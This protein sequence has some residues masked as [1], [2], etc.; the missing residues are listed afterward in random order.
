M[1]IELN[2]TLNREL[3]MKSNLNQICAVALLSAL[4]A[5]GGSK[6]ALISQQDINNARQAG[7]LSS[8]YSKAD[9]L[10]IESSGSSKE[11]MI[12][13]QSQIAKFLVEDQKTEIDRVLAENK[14]EYDLVDRNSLRN[15]IAQVEP[16]K[17]WDFSR[18]SVVLPSLKN[19]LDKT[20]HEISDAILNSERTSKD[21]VEHMQWLKKASVLAGSGSDEKSLYEMNLTKN[22]QML[23]TQGSEAYKKRMFNISLVS[24]QKGLELDPGNIQFESMA[25]QSDAALFEQS[26]RNALENG[27]PELAYQ[28]LQDVSDKPQMIQVKKKM[29][30]SILVLANYFANNAK[31][32]YK[33]NDLL[34]AYTEFNRGREI[35]KNLSVSNRGFIQEKEYL[36]MLMNKASKFE[37]SD[38]AV[39][40]LLS[41]IK[42]FDPGYPT[43]ENQIVSK[44]QSLKN[45]ATTKLSVTEFKEV[46]SSNSV[47]ASLGRRVGSKL[48]KILFDKLGDQLQIVADLSALSQPTQYSGNYLSVEGEVLQAAIETTKN[49]GQRSQNVLIAV[50]KTET[51]EYKEW[52]ERK[53]GDA[54]TQFLEEEIKEDILIQVEHIKKLAVT[55]VAYRIIA[56]TT[57]KVLVTNN[58]VK[59]GSYSGDSVNEYQ[60]G[61]FHQKYIAADLPSDIKIMDNLATELSKA[62]GE[63][64][65]KYLENPELSYFNAYQEAV[66][67]GENLNAVELISNAIVISSES[68]ENKDIWISV[69]KQQVLAL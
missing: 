36:D 38:G 40:G 16:M 2:R 52:S 37:K 13:I 12:G 19:Q 62:V 67:R 66:K 68:N 8:L 7:K 50:K 15:L 20:N 39:F 35:Q 28:V 44:Q 59:E 21:V 22:I 69:L 4:L 26:F 54:P 24:A 27:K 46:L 23:V 51:E 1:T 29:E 64:L 32:A 33:K 61:L 11:E 34:M 6:P 60:K 49:K 41:V 58:I 45:R 30:K 31:V 25:A 57:Q 47:V 9:Q 65:I 3:K 48:E 55:E 14:T 63:S 43:L 56:P 53:R 17:R 5:C 18:Y 42:E 10:I